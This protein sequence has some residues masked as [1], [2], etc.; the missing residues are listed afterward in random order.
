MRQ[1]SC[2]APEAYHIWHQ[3]PTIYGTTRA[4][5]RRTHTWPAP[6]VGR[7]LSTSRTRARVEWIRQVSS[8]RRT[9]QC[10]CACVFECAH[11]GSW[12]WA[13]VRGQIFACAFAPTCVCVCARAR[14]RLRPNA[15]C[16]PPCS[17]PAHPQA[18]AGPLLPL[19]PRRW[20]GSASGSS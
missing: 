4:Q 2:I 1:K 8:T 3:R 7:S 14:M 15:H 5:S 18:S 12:A 6:T 11:W 13:C 16:D 20:S 10:I 9:P 19:S 17:I